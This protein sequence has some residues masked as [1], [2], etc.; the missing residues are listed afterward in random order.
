[1]TSRDAIRTC[2][3]VAEAHALGGRARADEDGEEGDHEAYEI[4]EQVRGVGGDR[5]T[6]RQNATWW[7]QKSIHCTQCAL[8]RHTLLVQ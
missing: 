4:G 5:Q 1:M 3:I 6:A 8:S 7:T 2:T